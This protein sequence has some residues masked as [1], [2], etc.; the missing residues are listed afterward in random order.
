MNETMVTAK[1]AIAAFF[2]AIGAFLG[3]KGI[4]AL[5]WVVLMALDY[6]SGTLAAR[7]DGSWKSAVA[8]EGLWHKGGMILVV[9]VALIADMV[10]AVALQNIPVVN[11]AWPDVLLPLVLAWYIITELGSILENAIKL[12]A[13][14]PVWLVRILDAS[15]K[16]VETA[17]QNAAKVDGNALAEEYTPP[18]IAKTE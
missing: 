5:V 6:I 18:D 15:L 10:M 14:V 13:N 4:M 1:V 16:I 7:K 2:T 8:R 11:I 3:W 9:V 17:G 12:G